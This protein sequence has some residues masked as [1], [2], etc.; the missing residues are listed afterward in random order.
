MI[1][2]LRRRLVRPVVEQLTQGLSPDSIALTIAIGLAIAVIPV[3]GT[4]TLLC[5]TAA[6][7]LRL[8]QP[9]IQ[10]INYLSFP[11]QL[12]FI[13]PYLKLGRLLFGGPAIRMSAEELA[14]FVTSRPGEAFEVL[15][16]VTLQAVGAWALTAPLIAGAVFLAA[17]PFLRAAARR[18]RSA[19]TAAASPG[20]EAPA[21]G[22]VAAPVAGVEERDAR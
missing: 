5:T 7:A 19:R 21:S 17:R 8:N 2:F 9:L 1:E 15:W 11:L 10:A 4:T 12:A 18:L 22:P 6:I 20:P 13:V 3:V 14:A 16:R